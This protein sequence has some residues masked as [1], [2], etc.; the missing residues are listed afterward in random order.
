MTIDEAIEQLI[1]VGE[2]DPLTIARRIEQEYGEQDW[3]AQELIGRTE[4]IL[5]E[6]ARRRLGSVRRSAEIALRPGDSRSQGDLQLAGFWIP[7]EGWK[8]AA[9]VTAADLR[10]RAHFYDLLSL[11]SQRRATWCREVADMMDSE[12]AEKLGGLKAELPPLPDVE[13]LL[14]IEVA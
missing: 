4:E 11:A 5:A 7:G 1:H 14:E 3:L 6:W 13:E 12:G 9:D 10:T 2:K 8:R